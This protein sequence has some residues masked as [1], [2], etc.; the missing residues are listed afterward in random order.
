MDKKIIEADKMRVDH[1]INKKKER[2]Q[3]ENQEGLANL[4]LMENRRRIMLEAKEREK[5]EDMELVKRYDMQFLLKEHNYKN[6]LFFIDK[7]LIFK[8]NIYF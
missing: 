6:V 1:F 8:K 5:K 3:L 2:I 7:T 4:E